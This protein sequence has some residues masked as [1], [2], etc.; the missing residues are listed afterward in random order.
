[1]FRY[2]A[3]A[4]MAFFGAA[5]PCAAL[6]ACNGDKGDGCKTPS[7]C[8]ASLEPTDRAGTPWRSYSD[9]L[10][11]ARAQDCPGSAVTIGVCSDGKRF[12][13]RSGGF[14]GSYH[15]FKG[16]RL[17]GASYWSDVDSCECEDGEAQG[18]VSCGRDDDLGTDAC[19]SR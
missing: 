15:Y 4:K 12:I 19:P 14:A 17:V 8:A 3:L 10:E 13:S 18:D 11:A 1:M 9:D 5:L 16:D 7:Q 2:G 6:F